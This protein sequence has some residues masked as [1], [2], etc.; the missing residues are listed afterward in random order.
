MTYTVLLFVTR[1]PSLTFDAFQDYYE[2]KH[3]PLVYSVLSDVWPTTFHRRYFARVSRK[4]FGGPANPDHPPLMLRGNIDEVDCDCIAEMTFPS[5]KMFQKFYKKIYSKEIAALLAEDENNFLQSG[6][7][8]AVVIGETWS[9]GPDGV[10]TSEQSDVA[11]SDGSDSD[12]SSS[13]RSA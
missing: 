2:H 3:I 8:R 1:D 13:E 11:R 4:G 9:T 7:T 12:V 10:T 6:K 5:D